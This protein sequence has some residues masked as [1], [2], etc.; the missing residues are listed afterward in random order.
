MALPP[1]TSAPSLCPKDSRKGQQVTGQPHRDKGQI[2]PVDLNA[3]WDNVSKVNS[4]LRV[5]ALQERLSAGA[6][7]ASTEAGGTDCVRLCAGLAD[8]VEGLIVDRFGPL[9]VAVDYAGSTGGGL[10]A[11]E[12]LGLVRAGFPHHDVVAKVRS[13]SEAA[14]KY[15]TAIHREEA[16]T[17]PLVATERGLRFEIGTDPGHDFGLFLDAAIARL[18][19]RGAAKGKRVLNLFSYTGAFGIAAAKGGAID[20]A[21]VDPNRDYLAWSLRNAHLNDVTMR[22]LPDTAQTHLAR[23][24]RR[25]A[26]NPAHQPYDLVIADPPAFG[27]GRGAERV[28]RLFWPELFA[29]LRVMAP[30]TVVVMCNDKAFR[31]RQ[32]FVA[33]VESELGDLY[34]FERLGTRLT[35]DAL[36]IESPVLTWRPGIEDP[37]FAEP[38]VMAGT[39]RIPQRRSS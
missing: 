9:L 34:R 31:S 30:A 3:R 33:L 36:A 13:S 4:G 7:V 19:V 29:A 39:R 8:G 5:R 6:T 11:E 32:D 22:V 10:T 15:V 20:V 27:V 21:N 23:H 12:L 16:A 17:R 26:R 2:S 38:T 35:A 37:F 28:L 18:Y 25:L 14:N 1:R 24:L